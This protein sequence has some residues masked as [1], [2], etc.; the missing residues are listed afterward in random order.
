MMALRRKSATFFFGFLLHILTAGAQQNQFIYIQTGDQQAFFVKLEEKLFTSSDAGYVIISKLSTG[1]YGISIGFQNGQFPLQKLSCRVEESDAGYLL[2]RDDTTGWGLLNLQTLEL[3]MAQQEE[4]TTQRK[5]KSVTG[6]TFSEVLAAVVNDPGILN[7][8]VNAQDSATIE[9]VQKEQIEIMVP[10]SSTLKPVL[11]ELPKDSLVVY[12]EKI[13]KLS[14][15]SSAVGISILFLNIINDAA[16]TIN[17]FIPVIGQASENIDKGSIGNLNNPKTSIDTTRAL[18]SRFLDMELPNPNLKNDT[19]SSLSDSL[20][21]IEKRSLFENAGCRVIANYDD[22][23]EL[24]KQMSEETTENGKINAALKKFRVTCFTTEQV[25][26]LSK[27]FTNEEGKYRFYVAAYPYA[28]DLSNFGSLQSQ[29]ADEYYI[30]RF[31]AM[32]H[33]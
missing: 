22:V 10:D 30:S 21:I 13:S 3:Q 17:V 23:R 31:K 32:I 5:Q 16:D 9:V 28:S 11:A 19:I 20:V 18:N 8:Q 2:K 6:D 26:E 15:D 12:Q 25:K 29:L 7:A 14:I 4:T 24:E 33:N 27:L 1:V